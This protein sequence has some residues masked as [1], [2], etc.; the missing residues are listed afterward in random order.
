MLERTMETHGVESSGMRA[1][2]SL[3]EVLIAMGVLAVALP[4]V[5][6]V[7]ARAGMS[8]A[9]AQAETRCVVILPACMDEIKAAQ[10]GIA[11]FLPPSNRHSPFPAAAATLAFARDGHL[12]GNVAP[13]VYLAGVRQ[14]ANEPVRFLATLHTSPA[15]ILPNMPAMLSL[16]ISLEYP[17][18]APLAQRRHLDFHTCIP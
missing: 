16:R 12:L 10:H 9:A 14:L 15:P 7:L 4:L 2:S 6:A 18:A 3:I 11:R 5:F 13:E 17:A 8:C 1:G